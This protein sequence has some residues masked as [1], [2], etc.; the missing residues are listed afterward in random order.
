M[1]DEMTLDE[2]VQ[3]R[4]ERAVKR[5]EAENAALRAALRE[6][7]DLEPLENGL[8]RRP[9]VCSAT[10]AEAEP[11]CECWSCASARHFRAKQRARELLRE[12]P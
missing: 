4:L 12:K 11:A 2:R 9:V 7:L 8:H 5:L 10:A 6:V 3:A 1:G